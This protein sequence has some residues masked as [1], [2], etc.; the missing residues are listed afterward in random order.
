MAN[1][2]IQECNTI[3]IIEPD[4]DL[5]VDTT[6]ASADPSLTERGEEVLTA[7][8]T[9]VTVRFQTQK[10]TA[11]YRFEYLYVDFIG[12]A[13][14]NP[15]PGTI[16]A[17]PV[18]QS[19]TE[20]VVELAGF[21]V[22]AGYVLRWRVVVTEISAIAVIDAPESMRIQL[23]GLHPGFTSAPEIKMDV[24]FVNPRSN[25]TYGFSEFRIENLVDDPDDQSPIVVQ[26]YAKQTD[27]F[28]I[29]WNPYAPT[30][31]YF[32]VARTP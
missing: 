17:V 27:K 21:P 31:N 23:P 10:L 13:Q 28:S 22:T 20:F 11:G 26:V 12:S 29:T 19:L 32:L 8:Q 16:Q 2:S 25:T 7:G 6:G 3:Q 1:S 14:D 4:G 5:P 18:Q 9:Q 15:N 24:P 30:E